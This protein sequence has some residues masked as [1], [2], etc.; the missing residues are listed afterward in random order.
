MGGI[1][2]H[3]KARSERL[4]AAS[5]RRHQL[6]EERRSLAANSASGNQQQSANAAPVPTIQ[7]EV[8]TYEAPVEPSD[9]ASQ[10]KSNSEHQTQQQS[11]SEHQSQQQSDSEHQAQQQSDSEHQAQPS[12]SRAGVA[13]TSTGL[14][15][16]RI[17]DIAAVADGIDTLLDHAKDCWKPSFTSEMRNGLQTYLRYQCH[18][19]GA[20]FDVA[21]EQT[22]SLNS[23]AVYAAVTT[24]SGFTAMKTQMSLMEVPFMTF[25]N[26]S[27]IEEDI[28]EVSTHTVKHVAD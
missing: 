5:R 22:H 11:N 18:K 2:K 27:K 7:R 6:A 23:Q 1:K 14:A 12:S 20:E 19:C 9:Q 21:K 25:P 16:R 13:E 15:G 24:G 10:Q 17:V 4:R 28:G 26:F 3:V 8:A